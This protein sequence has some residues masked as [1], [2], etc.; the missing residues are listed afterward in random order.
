MGR[1]L[2]D[3]IYD[4]TPPFVALYILFDRESITS[5]LHS[6]VGSSAAVTSTAQ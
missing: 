3:L 2:V 4:D 6:T 5:N 1:S